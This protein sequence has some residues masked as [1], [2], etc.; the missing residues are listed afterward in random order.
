MR[1][2][3]L[4]QLTKIQI[5]T[6][7][8]SG[9]YRS[10][11][12]TMEMVRANHAAVRAFLR[13]L[14]GSYADAD[15]IAQEAFARTWEVLDRFDGS[16]RLRTFICGVAFQYWRRARRSSMRRQAR[17]DAYA[18]DAETET[19]QPARAGAI[20]LVA[21][22]AR[23]DLVDELGLRQRPGPGH[24]QTLGLRD[25]LVPR[26]LLEIPPLHGGAS[27]HTGHDRGG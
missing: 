20:P 6:A 5:N 11:E 4:S 23:E 15:D 13:R 27:Y 8:L 18:A 26:Q 2:H 3:A 7:G 10:D 25:Q 19:E 24:A 16:S 17:E 1:R 21:H 22:R 12:E 9:P 14:V